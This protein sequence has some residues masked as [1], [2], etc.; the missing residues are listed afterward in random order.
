[1]YCE[2]LE[3]YS[4]Q[5]LTKHTLNIHPF[6]SNSNQLLPN[7]E[8]ALESSQISLIVNIPELQHPDIQ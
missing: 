1:M 4:L 3:E 7:E 6:N 8:I 2:D 5:N